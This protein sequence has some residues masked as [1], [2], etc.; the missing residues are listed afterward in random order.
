MSHRF[1]FKVSV[2]VERES[3]KFAARDEISDALLAELE[4]SDPGTVGGLGADG[5][6]DYNVIDFTVEEL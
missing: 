4:L 5:M 6:T 1:E 3:G 2:E